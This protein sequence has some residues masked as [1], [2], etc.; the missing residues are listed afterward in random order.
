[1]ISWSSWQNEMISGEVSP[2]NP[3]FGEQVQT[4]LV[5]EAGLEVIMLPG[6]ILKR[7]LSRAPSSGE[8]R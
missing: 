3:V 2:G 8:Y 5:P 4:V 6:R 1:M 7:I